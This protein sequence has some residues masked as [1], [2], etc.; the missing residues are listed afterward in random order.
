MSSTSQGKKTDYYLAS[1][2]YRKKKQTGEL[3]TYFFENLP[4][5]FHIFTLFLEIP[6]KTK[7]NPWKFQKIVLDPLET[8]RPKTKTPGNSTLFLLGRPCKF[9]F[10]FN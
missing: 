9:R 6:D 5:I 7:L 8:L 2:Y 4:E 1:G 10:T 3:R